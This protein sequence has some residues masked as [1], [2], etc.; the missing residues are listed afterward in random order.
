V[1]VATGDTDL[2]AELKR[3]LKFVRSEKE[4]VKKTPKNAGN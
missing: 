3:G 1:H 2:T 4:T